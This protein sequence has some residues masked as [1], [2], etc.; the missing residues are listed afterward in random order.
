MASGS[1]S[2]IQARVFR[3]PRRQC[4]RGECLCSPWLVWRLSSWK[5]V[6][7]CFESKTN[8]VHGLIYEVQFTFATT[9]KKAEI[10]TAMWIG[11]YY[12]PSLYS[13]RPIQRRAWKNVFINIC[14]CI[15]ITKNTFFSIQI[16]FLTSCQMHIFLVH[17]KLPFP[18]AGHHKPF[19]QSLPILVF[20]RFTAALQGSGVRCFNFWNGEDLTFLKCQLAPLS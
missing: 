11:I 5:P 3:A 10:H 2:L 14:I 6:D 4:A 13:Y 20:L 1:G 16:S 12:S 17:H 18:S 15:L 19:L 8:R 7:L 9:T